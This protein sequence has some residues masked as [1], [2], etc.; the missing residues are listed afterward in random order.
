MRLNFLFKVCILFFIMQYILSC[1]EMSKRNK[2]TRQDE[3]SHVQKDI[4]DYRFEVNYLLNNSIDDLKKQKWFRSQIS[5]SNDEYDEWLEG[6]F[7]YSKNKWVRIIYG[8]INGKHPNYLESNS[9]VFLNNSKL[10]VGDFLKNIIHYS[11]ISI[12]YDEGCLILKD[13]NNQYYLDCSENLDIADFEKI[14][15][16]KESK[17]SD[18]FPEKLKNCM[19]TYFRINKK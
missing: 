11:E 2:T 18:A 17:S 16:S 14:I 13:N 4:I 8:D 5:I 15:E 19:V 10:K 6:E 9:N 12:D 1:N 3:I 7:Y